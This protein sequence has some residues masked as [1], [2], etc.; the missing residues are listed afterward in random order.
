LENLPKTSQLKCRKENIEI[1]YTFNTPASVKLIRETAEQMYFLGFTIYALG[2]DGKWEN[3]SSDEGWKQQDP[4][5]YMLK[6][7]ARLIV[8]NFAGMYYKAAYF[9]DVSQQ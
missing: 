2:A 8:K 1:K 3:Y 7:K 4:P 5:E 6:T 9:S